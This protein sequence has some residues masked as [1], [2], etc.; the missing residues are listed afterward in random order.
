V[1]GGAAAAWPLAA[2]AQQSERLRQVGVFV[3]LA[4]SADDPVARETVR[5]FSEA[6]QAAGWLE[7]KNIHLHYR[8]GGDPAKINASASELVTLAP[9]VIYAQ[10]LP[11]T[12]ALYQKTHTIP[13]V[14]TQV[15]DPFGFGLVDSE[16][17][18]GGNVTGFV[19]WDLSIGGKWTQLLRD[20]APDV[21]HIGV[22]YNPD[23]APYARPL[24]SSSKGAAGASV[25]VVECPVR[26]DSEIEGMHR[27]WRANL[28]AAYWSYPSPLRTHAAIKLLPNARGS[29]CLPSIRFRV[30]QGAGRCYATRMPSIQ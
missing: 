19:V 18:P 6:M 29:I 22:F 2:R 9:E 1:S 23:T 3:G 27:C 20:I 8:F 21:T 7:G 5:P 10:G 14:F 17:H 25:T 26:D 12:R 28:V 11:A 16:A 13:I 15:A 30:Q 4:S 24:I